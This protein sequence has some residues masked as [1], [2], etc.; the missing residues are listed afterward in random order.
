MKR[1]DLWDLFT[2]SYFHK[3][4]FWKLHLL[5]FTNG[6]LNDVNSILGGQQ[7]R[8]QGYYLLN[9]DAGRNSF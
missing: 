7:F 2:D 6:P 3:A 9:G 1:A 4:M 5:F 8:L